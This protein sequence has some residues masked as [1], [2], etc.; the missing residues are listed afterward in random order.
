MTAIA[1]YRTAILAILDDPSLARY[2]NDQVDAALRQALRLYAGFRPIIRTYIVDGSD[3]FQITM[4]A[5]FLA[6]QVLSVHLVNTDYDPPKEIA[7]YATLIDEQWTIETRDYKVAATES[8]SVE[9]SISHTVDGLDSAAGTTVPEEDELAVQMSA[10]GYC[11]L[12]RAASRTETINLQP[13]VAAGLIN[14]GVH[15]LDEFAKFIHSRP[16]VTI[17]VPPDMVSDDF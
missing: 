12:S 10:A 9:Y 17:S 8:I 11:C 4:P 6:V 16:S 5:D 7:F 14:L 13:D 2:T 3:T 1:G 15:L